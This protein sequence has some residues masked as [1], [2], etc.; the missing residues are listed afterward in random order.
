MPKRKKSP[1]KWK[2]ELNEEDHINVDNDVDL[3]KKIDEIENNY[4]NKSYKLLITKI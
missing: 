4:V 3:I 2:I 1:R